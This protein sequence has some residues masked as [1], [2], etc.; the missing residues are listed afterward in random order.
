[1][2]DLVGITLS[3]RYFLRRPIGSGGMADVYLAWDTDRSTEM[4]I[5]V[6]RRDLANNTRFRKRFAKEAE[7]LRKLDHPNIVRLYAFDEDDGVVF[8]VMDWVEGN[9][10]RQ[11][12]TERKQPFSLEEVSHILRPIASALN[13]AHRKK[14][15][16]CDVKPANIL[17]DMDKRVFLSDFG[18]ARLASEQQGGGTPP[19][20]APEQFAGGVIDGRTDVYALGVTLYEILSGGQ[21]PFHGDSPFSAGKTTRE[22][23]AWEHLNLPLP[24]LTQF[25][26]GL[27]SSVVNVINTALNKEPSLRYPTAMALFADFERA[28]GKSDRPTASPSADQPVRSK[29]IPKSVDISQSPSPRFPKPPPPIPPGSTHYTPLPPYTKSPPSQVMPIPLRG[30][31]HGPHLYCRSGDFA[32][33]SIPILKQGLTIGRET[34]KQLPLRERSVSRSHATIIRTRRGVYIRDEKSTM[35]TLVN[36]KRIPANIP[37]LLKHGDVIQMGH[38]QIFEFRNK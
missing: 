10:L 24:P 12:I 5:K 33:Q 4:A 21:V 1:M 16:H 23:I 2:A 3:N 27:S 26:S 7:F 25:N 6:L 17:I 37:I 28:R 20:M 18:V 19:Y 14:I 15:Y 35:G 30:Q 36:G 34:N 38:Y 31:V 9:D 8:V 32:K 22:R 13:Y 11:V 29:T